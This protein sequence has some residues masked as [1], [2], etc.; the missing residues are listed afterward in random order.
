VTN[1]NSDTW[2]PNYFWLVKQYP[3][4]WSEAGDRICA[5]KDER[6]QYRFRYATHKGATSRLRGVS[7]CADTSHSPRF[8]LRYDDDNWSNEE[9]VWPASDRSF[10]SD[11]KRDGWTYRKNPTTA[12]STDGEWLGLFWNVCCNVCLCFGKLLFELDTAQSMVS[13]C[14]CVCFLVL[15]PFMDVLVLILVLFCLSPFCLAFLPFS[16]LLFQFL[17]TMQAPPLLKV[18]C[19]SRTT[20]DLQ[21]PIFNR[22]RKSTTIVWGRKTGMQFVPSQIVNFYMDPYV[23][24]L[25]PKQ[26]FTLPC[27]CLF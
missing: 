5:H 8:T 23:S 17:F 18:H 1:P 11:G 3:Y 13:L 22:A 10:P 12:T 25:G 4:Y 7:C 24:C 9:A 26:M 21:D 2:D 27:F 20:V 15:W 19:G 6:N 14:L 16:F